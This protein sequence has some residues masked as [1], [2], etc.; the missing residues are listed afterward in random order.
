MQKPYKPNFGGHTDFEILREFGERLVALGIPS[1][2]VHAHEPDPDRREILRDLQNELA[3]E[4]R[5]F[6]DAL[7]RNG[8]DVPTQRFLITSVFDQKLADYRREAEAAHV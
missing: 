4:A 7:A 2:W 8:H 6:V 3:A 5:P 1:R